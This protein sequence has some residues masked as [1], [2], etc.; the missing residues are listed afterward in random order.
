MS[1]ELYDWQTKDVAKMVRQSGS[2]NGS[3][4]G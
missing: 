1:L 3:E 2:A 4:M